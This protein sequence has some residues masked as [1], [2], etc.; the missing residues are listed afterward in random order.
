MEYD[1]ASKMKSSGK[2]SQI[3]EGKF[4]LYELMENMS[5]VM[6]IASK[7]YIPLRNAFKK[8]DKFA[9]FSY[10]IE[11]RLRILPEKYLR[12]S[13]NSIRTYSLVSLMFKSKG[14]K[15]AQILQS[16]LRRNL[17]FSFTYFLFSIIEK[18]E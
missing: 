11:S 5:K 3:S 1:S 4:K 16:K 10:K 2:S 8:I 6:A 7:M 18:S 14:F 12:D 15:L 9:L 13:L 17:I